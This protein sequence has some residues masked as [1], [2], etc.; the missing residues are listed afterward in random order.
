LE[1]EA[2][3]SAEVEALTVMASLTS[4]GELVQASVLL[5]PEATA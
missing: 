1:N 4:A 2:R 5:L 3:A